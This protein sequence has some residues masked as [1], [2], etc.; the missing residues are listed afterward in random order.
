MNPKPKK[1][2]G[3]LRTY[4]IKCN[5]IDKNGLLVLDDKMQEKVIVKIYRDGKSMPLCRYLS[6]DNENRCSAPLNDEDKGFCQ[7]R[8]F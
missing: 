1:L 4:S 6:G 3:L 5:G 8:S 2:E 7:Y